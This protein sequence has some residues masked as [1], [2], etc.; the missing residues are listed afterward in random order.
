MD[1]LVTNKTKIRESR[2]SK[3]IKIITQKRKRMINQVL[4]NI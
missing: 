2:M 4:S 3:F 1:E